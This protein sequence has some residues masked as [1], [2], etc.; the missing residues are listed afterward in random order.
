MFLTEEQGMDL[1][2]MEIDI[3]YFN[4]VQELIEEMAYFNGKPVEYIQEYNVGGD[5]T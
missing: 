1:K 5:E 4:Q 3:G 2:A